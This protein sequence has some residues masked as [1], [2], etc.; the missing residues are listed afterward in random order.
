[1]RAKIE[2][3]TFAPGAALMFTAALAEYGIPVEK[4]ARATVA[5][6]RPG[7]SANTRVSLGG[8]P[9]CVFVG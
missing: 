2:Q 3:S 4:R 1:M 7:G 8:F 6:T 5:L 9:R